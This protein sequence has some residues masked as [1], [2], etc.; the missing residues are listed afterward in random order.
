MGP[1]L[2]PCFN[3]ACCSKQR[4]SSLT[5]HERC[6]LAGLAGRSGHTGRRSNRRLDLIGARQKMNTDKRYRADHD[7]LWRNPKM[8]MRAIFVCTGY[9]AAIFARHAALFCML[10]TAAGHKIDRFRCRV[11]VIR[12]MRRVTAHAPVPSSQRF[13]RQRN[14]LA[15]IRGHAIPFDR[16]QDSLFA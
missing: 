13:R 12:S 16:V 10:R 9:P 5:G 4:K 3:G 14:T 7:S 15:R 11:R 6:E 1:T 2:R 8:K